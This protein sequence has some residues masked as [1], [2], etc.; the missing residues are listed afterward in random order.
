MHV[1]VIALFLKFVKSSFHIEEL[2]LMACFCVP[3]FVA[4]NG[5]VLEN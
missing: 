3:A 1:S 4:W 2:Y 5:T